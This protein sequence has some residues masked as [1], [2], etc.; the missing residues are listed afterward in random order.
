MCSPP[1]GTARG[2][3]SV[4]LN[5]WGLLLRTTWACHRSLGA[6]RAPCCWPTG[7]WQGAFHDK[8]RQQVPW[9]ERRWSAV[10]KRACGPPVPLGA[11]GQREIKSRWEAAHL[12]RAVFQGLWSGS[13]FLPALQL[14]LC[15][16]RHRLLRPVMTVSNYT[17]C[18]PTN[19]QIPRSRFSCPGSTPRGSRIPPMHLISQ[20][21]QSSL[22]CKVSH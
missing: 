2:N 13:L 17:A 7:P 8:G 3:G 22:A 19:R 21:P 4:V 15:E 6:V 20:A 10:F 16:D 18:Y 1:P 9:Q 5:T 12:P 11:G 14:I